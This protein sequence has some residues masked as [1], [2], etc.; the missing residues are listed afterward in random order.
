MPPRYSSNVND[1]WLNAVDG[2]LA[3]SHLSAAEQHVGRGEEEFAQ[4]GRDALQAGRHK[5]LVA[6]RTARGALDGRGGGG[7]GLSAWEQEGRQLL[8]AGLHR[9]QVFKAPQQRGL[10][11]S[12]SRSLGKASYGGQ[13]SGL[14]PRVKRVLEAGAIAVADAGL[15]E[16]GR[17]WGRREERERT[18]RSVLN[19]VALSPR[20][21]V[22]Y[23]RRRK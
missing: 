13:H 6:K 17:A 11:S 18:E 2:A 15:V 16:M 1:N 3:R 5:L 20:Q 14:D 8:D 7:T 10:S 21:T 22:I 23:L 4:A 9:V 19:G 12:S